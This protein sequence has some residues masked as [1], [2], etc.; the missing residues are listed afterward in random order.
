MLGMIR[1]LIVTGLTVA[2]GIWMWENVKSRVPDGL[3]ERF[4]EVTGS[5]PV[6][7]GDA[8]GPNERSQRTRLVPGTLGQRFLAWAIFVLLMPVV[9]APLAGRVF[10]RESNAA[11]MALVFGYTGLGV[12]AAYF[13]DFIHVGGL[14]LGI[15]YLAGLLAVFCYDLWICAL[16]AKLR[17]R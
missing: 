2:A 6:A 7:S 14:F 10:A 13:V 15:A 3:A 1:R 16:L 17:E 4:R 8:S 12:L 9:T 5:E 11:N